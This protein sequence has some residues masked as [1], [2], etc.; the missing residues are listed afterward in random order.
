MNPLSTNLGYPQCRWSKSIAAFLNYEA[1]TTTLHFL[2]PQLTSSSLLVLECEYDFTVTVNFTA[3]LQMSIH[4]A[5]FY[6]RL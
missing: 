1:V 6:A 2:L 4:A 5:A 3:Y